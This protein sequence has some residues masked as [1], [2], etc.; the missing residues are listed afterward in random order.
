MSPYFQ[1]C[2][3]HTNLRLQEGQLLISSTHCSAAEQN[4]SILHFLGKENLG[5]E[6]NRCR[7]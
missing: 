5:M 4:F 3:L 6:F 7:S 2:F 1:G